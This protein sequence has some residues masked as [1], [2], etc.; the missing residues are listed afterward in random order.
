[1]EDF[2]VIISSQLIRQMVE[3]DFKFDDELVDHYVN[4]LKT[5]V[6]RLSKHPEL[7]NLFYSNTLKTFPLFNQAQNFSNHPDQLVRTSVR[8][9][10]LTLI[11]MDDECHLL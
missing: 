11:S 8:T 3:C 9:I 5:L 1:M 4:F 10:T 2:I 7:L 6:L